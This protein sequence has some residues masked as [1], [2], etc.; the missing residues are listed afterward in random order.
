MSWLC[1]CVPFCCCDALCADCC[2]CWSFA[3]VE[4][5]AGFCTVLAGQDEV[6]DLKKK[7]NIVQVPGRPP[8]PW[9]VLQECCCNSRSGF[10]CCPFQDKHMV[11]LCLVVVHGKLLCELWFHQKWIFCR[12]DVL[13]FCQTIVAHLSPI[14]VCFQ[15]VYFHFFNGNWAREY[16]KSED[17]DEDVE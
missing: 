13:V 1:E 15:K 6:I 11:L 9:V 14:T 8:H 7:S 2:H 17:K 12:A 10:L 5:N 4:V 16:N 3:Q